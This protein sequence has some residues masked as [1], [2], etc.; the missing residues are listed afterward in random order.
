MYIDC[1]SLPKHLQE[2]YKSMNT[3]FNDECTRVS[4]T[5]DG[6]SAEFKQN[7]GSFYAKTSL[8]LNVSAE[9]LKDIMTEL[10]HEAM[11]AFKETYNQEYQ[12]LSATTTMD[13]ESQEKLK[14][15]DDFARVV[16]PKE[17]EPNEPEGDEEVRFE[18]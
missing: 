3:K 18:L 4:K 14:V 5:G 10:S 16:R 11:L 1:L 9:Q 8:A 15:V 7:V 13:A 2:E 17:D 6:V 12:K